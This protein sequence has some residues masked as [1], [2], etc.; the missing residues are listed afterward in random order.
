MKNQ[1]QENLD[2]AVKEV[3]VMLNCGMTG[4]DAMELL[5]EDQRDWTLFFEYLEDIGKK[6]LLKRILT[7]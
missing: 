2:W 4:E 5:L 6:K 1:T 7:S 3:E